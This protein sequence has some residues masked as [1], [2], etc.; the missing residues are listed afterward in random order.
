MYRLFV[1]EWPG[2]IR[3]CGRMTGKQGIILEDPI[4]AITSYLLTIW[5]LPEKHQPLRRFTS[6]QE[7]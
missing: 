3:D 1:L 6:N 5:E 2:Q 4:R 7:L